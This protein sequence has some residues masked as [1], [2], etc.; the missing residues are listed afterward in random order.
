MVECSLPVLPP[1]KRRKIER[2]KKKERK[3][4]LLSTPS[5]IKKLKR[6]KSGLTRGDNSNAAALYSI[7][8]FEF[9]IHGIVRSRASSLKIRQPLSL[10]ETRKPRSQLMSSGIETSIIPVDYDSGINQVP[11]DTDLA[12]H[13]VRLSLLLLDETGVVSVTLGDDFKALI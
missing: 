10:A 7:L 4:V 8:L 2:K 6:K 5:E 9:L 13:A 12:Q 3:G 1:E 11:L